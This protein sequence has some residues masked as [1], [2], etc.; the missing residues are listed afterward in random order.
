MSNFGIA[1]SVTY[2]RCHV[3]LRNIAILGR[4]GRFLYVSCCIIEKEFGNV[5]ES[6]GQS[7]P[8]CPFGWL[9]LTP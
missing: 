4:L 7:R 6:V 1:P 2:P 9:G 8:R 3:S 5:R